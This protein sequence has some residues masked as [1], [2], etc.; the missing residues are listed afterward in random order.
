MKAVA[1]QK[2]DERYQDYDVPVICYM[3]DDHNCGQIYG[4]NKNV[5]LRRIF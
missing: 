5:D 2:G 1:E 3:P 4:Q